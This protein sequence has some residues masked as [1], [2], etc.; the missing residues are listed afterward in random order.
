MDALRVRRTYGVHGVRPNS[1]LRANILGRREAP[2]CTLISAGKHTTLMRT[3]GNDVSHATRFAPRSATPRPNVKTNNPSTTASI[4][5]L[6]YL[7]K[8]NLSGKRDVYYFLYRKHLL[9]TPLHLSPYL[10]HPVA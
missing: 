6:R 5:F 9:A 8:T 1:L 2:S 3:V 4:F 7:L 10:G